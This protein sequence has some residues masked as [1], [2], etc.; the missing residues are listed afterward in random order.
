MHQSQGDPGHPRAHLL[1][2]HDSTPSQELVVD[3]LDW[4]RNTTRPHCL[5]EEMGGTVSQEFPRGFCPSLLS[6]FLAPGLSTAPQA[7]Q[8]WLCPSPA[9]RPPMAPQVLQD[10][11]RPVSLGYKAHRICL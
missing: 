8:R 4:A 7:P 11:S 10:K 2:L 3:N 1:P 5:W 6:G 9:H